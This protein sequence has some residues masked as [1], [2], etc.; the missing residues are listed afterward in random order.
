M[1]DFN[2]ERGKHRHSAKTK[3]L[4]WSPFVLG[5][6]LMIFHPLY[7]SVPW[8]TMK[9]ALYVLLGLGMLIVLL[10]EIFWAIRKPEGVPEFFEKDERE[11]RITAQLT[12]KYYVMLRFLID[13]GATAFIVFF[14]GL[15]I[16]ALWIGLALGT[17]EIFMF[18]GFR[19]EASRRIVQK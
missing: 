8:S 4:I 18:V 11:Q 13:A 17:I 9:I 14:P 10:D 6:L 19:I 7:R 3:M 5:F 15:Q 12:R 1:F 2:L 16:R